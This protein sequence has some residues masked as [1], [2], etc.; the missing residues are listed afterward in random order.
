MNTYEH[1]YVTCANL[2]GRRYRR[3]RCGGGNDVDVVPARQ[4]VPLFHQKGV[5]RG[6]SSRQPSSNPSDLEPSRYSKTSR[7]RFEGVAWNIGAVH[8][9]VLSSSMNGSR[10]PSVCS[11][12]RSPGA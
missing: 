11:A 12:K 1:L 2:C 10:D 9:A 5:A 4:V 8:A 7:L 3:V 6:R